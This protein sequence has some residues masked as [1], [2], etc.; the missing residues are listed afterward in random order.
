LGLSEATKE[1]ASAGEPPPEVETVM[2]Y[3]IFWGVF[4]AFGVMIIVQGAIVGEKAFQGSAPAPASEE[5]WL[6]LRTELDERFEAMAA[7]L[8]QMEA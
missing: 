5:E 1:A 8:C 4:V 6:D 7:S 2:L 3:S